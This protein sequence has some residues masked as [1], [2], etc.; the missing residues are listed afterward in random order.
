V[1]AT[2]GFL[3]LME[4]IGLAAVPLAARALGRIPGAGL[5]L[6]KVLGLLLVTW[7]VWMAGSLG[8]PNGTGLAVA[9][10][11]ALALMGLAAS[12]LGRPLEA[13]P[14][15]RR[16]LVAA[17]AVFAVVF[18]GSALYMA[19][20]SDVWGTEKPMDMALTNAT[21]VSPSFP[22]HDPWLS[23]EQLNYYYLG[24]LAMGLLIRLTG[25]EPTMGYNLAMAVV[26]ALAATATF[27]LGATLA[28][29]ARRRGL[30]VRRPLL[31]G[32]T[33]L[34]LLLLMGNLRGGW[35]AIRF[36]GPWSTF[37]WFAQSRIIPDT[38]NEFPFF[39][40]VVGDLH[41]HVIAVPLTLLAIAFAVQAA[42][43]GPPRM[44][45][46]RGWWETFCAALA[47]GFLYAVNS[48]S[49]PIAVGLLAL[50]IAVWAV[51]AEARGRRR[52]AAAWGVAVIGGGLV[53]VLPFLVDFDPNA[54]GFGI[55]GEREAFGP[56]TRHNLVMYGALLWVLA[57]MYAGRLRQVRNPVRVIVW[58]GALAVVALSLLAT[59]NLAGGAAVGLM[60]LVAIVAAFSREL[61]RPERLL[62]LFA[63]GGLACIAG[64]ELLYVRDEFQGTQFFRMNTVF[65]MGYQAWILLALA[66]GVV[67][68]AAPAWL[69]RLPRVVWRVGAV[70]LVAL[71]LA[72]TLVGSVGRKAGFAG[73]PHL[74]GRAWLE[75]TSPG[76]VAAI[77]WLRSEAPGDA[78][79]LEAVGDDYSPF[80]NARVSTY[81]GLATVLGWQGHELQWSHT[82]GTR[83][84]DVQSLY[85][86]ADPE[87]ARRLLTTYRV[88]Y[89][90]VGPLERTTY[91]EP[92]VAV[93]L[94]RKVFS[95]DGTVVYEYAVPR[96]AAP[97]PAPHQ[98]G[99]GA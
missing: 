23:G 37:D 12:R 45:R 38:I 46:L 58:G 67:L 94:G 68:V 28:E 69:P 34:V 39:S 97:K 8:I 96:G 52:R 19:Y 81:T 47:I 86:T 90:V 78:V 42:L 50:G 88:R 82:V 20:Y 9:G 1:I 35:N 26:F 85:S 15:R 24:Q 60:A 29:A 36:S 93:T 79:V 10:L 55:V 41:A 61:S 18:L 99:L 74:D 59:A 57:A 91:G 98:G 14:F 48:W 51:D 92:G 64:P 95:R 5:G 65:K 30:P 56:F 80:G 4:A 32:A 63:A 31:G 70:G 6:A 2:L 43:E 76:D 27:T 84:E 53:L 49:W 3:L 72:F 87:L 62:W 22:P 17:E 89:A 71:S 21:I 7:L 40:L 54:R 33:T 75:R 25:V 83:R 77:D 13:D 66:G 11:V 73:S 44:V 16:L